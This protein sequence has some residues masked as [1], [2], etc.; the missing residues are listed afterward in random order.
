MKTSIL[1]IIGVVLILISGIASFEI[2]KWRDH[3]ECNSPE[4]QALKTELSTLQSNVQSNVKILLKLTDNYKLYNENKTAANTLL[5][6]IEY[7]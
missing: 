1:V 6:S 4:V 7:S 3:S 2:I 5:S